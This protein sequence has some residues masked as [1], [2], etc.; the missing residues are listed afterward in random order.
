MWIFKHDTK[1]VVPKIQEKK[2]RK[3]LSSANLK[4]LLLY[5]HDPVEKKERESLEWMKIFARNFSVKG[6]ASKNLKR[7]LK[8]VKHPIRLQTKVLCLKACGVR[9]IITHMDISGH[10]S[11]YCSLLGSQVSK[12]T[13]VSSSTPGRLHSTFQYCVWK[14]STQHYENQSAGRELSGQE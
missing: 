9:D 1:N 8:T 2:K 3:S 6:P 14:F 4:L 5:T 13:D 7:T 11:H 10:A 12:T